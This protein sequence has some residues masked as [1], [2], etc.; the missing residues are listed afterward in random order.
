ML[1]PF[2]EEDN[3]DAF[4]TGLAEFIA[5]ATKT[6]GEEAVQKLIKDNHIDISGGS[7]R[8]ETNIAVER[9]KAL[10]SGR[11]AVSTDILKNYM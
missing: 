6:A 3:A 5:G 1:P 4:F 8:K 11:T 9:A 10:A 7:G 2:A